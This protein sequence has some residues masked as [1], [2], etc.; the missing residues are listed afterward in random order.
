MYFI[1]TQ[2]FD[3][4]MPVCSYNRSDVNQNK[5]LADETYK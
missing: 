3:R 1:D 5:K 4:T 2:V